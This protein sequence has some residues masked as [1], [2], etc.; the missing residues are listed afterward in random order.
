MENNFNDALKKLSQIFHHGNKVIYAEEVV[1]E[2]KELYSL[3][4]IIR[5]AVASKIHCMHKEIDC[6]MIKFIESV[7][8]SYELIFSDNTITE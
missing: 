8:T 5:K 3:R 7:N 4:N 1:E 6:L 2:V